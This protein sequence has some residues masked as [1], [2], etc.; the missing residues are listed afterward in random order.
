MLLYLKGKR[1]ISDEGAADTRITHDSHGIVI[2]IETY[3]HT[4]HDFIRAP[5]SDW[6]ADTRM[7]KLVEICQA[8]VDAVVSSP[9]F[10]E[11][12]PMTVYKYAVEG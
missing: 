8:A 7:E 3:S 5:I 12:D 11:L 9:Q 10:Q 6:H 2:M 4:I 1:Q